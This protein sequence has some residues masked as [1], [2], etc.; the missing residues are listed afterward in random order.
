MAPLEIITQSG[1]LYYFKLVDADSGR[2]VMRFFLHGG[3]PFTTEVPLGRYYLKY[4]SGSDWYG[5]QAHFGP[6]TVY[7]MPSV[8]LKFS[9]NGDGYAGHKLTLYRVRGGNLETRSIS[10]G[11]F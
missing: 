4:A 11:D 2:A 5:E 9:Q 6:A 1:I 7:S 3:Q 8:A 10:R